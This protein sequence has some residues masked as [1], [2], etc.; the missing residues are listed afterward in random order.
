MHWLKISAGLL[1]KK[2]REKIGPAL[3]EFLW[4]INK[5]YEGGAVCNSEPI[6]ASRIASDLGSTV[7][8]VRRNLERLEMEQY[9]RSETVPGRGNRYFIV[10]DKKLGKDDGVIAPKPKP[11]TPET[12]PRHHA[13]QEKI[14]SLWKMKNPNVP[15]APWEGREA[16]TLSQFLKSHKQWTLDNILTCVNHRF[17]SDTNHSERPGVWLSKLDSYLAAPLNQYNKPKNG[18][19]HAQPNPVGPNLVELSRKA[20][21]VT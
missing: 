12:D 4:L 7:A 15:T 17:Q 13:I 18:N 3:W 5:Q 1:E 10:K 14:V 19:G 2:H 20:G 21:I 8:T 11:S 6:A 9:I 16:G